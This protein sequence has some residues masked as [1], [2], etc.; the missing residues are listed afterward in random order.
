MSHIEKDNNVNKTVSYNHTNIIVKYQIKDRRISLP[1][2][3]Y[4]DE[5][6]ERKKD[7]HFQLKLINKVIFFGGHALAV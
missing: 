1:S 4:H 6:Q 2:D 5:E 7:S 3:H